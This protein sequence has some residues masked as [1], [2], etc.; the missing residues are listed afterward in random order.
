MLTRRRA[1]Q[2]LIVAIGVLLALSAINSFTPRS[3]GPASSSYATAADGLAGYA[4][5]LAQSGHP[6]TRVR[7]AP[8]HAKLDPRE[9]LVLLDPDVIVPAD[10]SALRA[11]VSAGGRL[12]AGGREPGAWLSKLLAGAPEWSASGATTSTPLLPVSE[13]AGVGLTE[14]DGAGAW[15]NPNAALPV[16]GEADRSLVAVAMLGAGQIVLLADST[17]LQNHLLAHA[18]NAALGLSLVGGSHR[19]VA[20]DEAV[21]GYGQRSGLAALPTRW[22]WTLVGLLL[23]ALVMVAARIRRLGPAQPP[24][25]PAFP[26]RLAHVEALA[27]ALGRTGS[28]AAAAR[29]VQS[30]AQRLLR[31]RTGI[32]TDA[33]AQATAQAAAALGLDPIEV[34]ALAAPALSDDD[35]LAVGSAL[36]KLSGASR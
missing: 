3:S 30:H 25:P 12:I 14:S 18:D 7:A 15:S 33:D 13:T 11:F 31:Q 34:R 29:T 22:K 8:A 32:A 4:A 6:V 19:P 26:P 2:L 21:H 1:K 28:P 35:V 9:T 5:L 23:A 16:L 24:A 27:S 36:A 20:F 10:I 17:P